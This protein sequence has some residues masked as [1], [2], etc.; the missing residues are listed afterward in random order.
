MRAATILERTR[1]GFASVPL[2][3]VPVGG[4]VAALLLAALW[5]LSPAI[6]IV[7]G[8][9]LLIG[10]AW[11]LGVLLRQVRKLTDRDPLTGAASRLCFANVLQREVQECHRSGRPV[12]V[13]VL[14][15]DNF[16]QLNE[17]FGHAVGDAVLIEVA[18]VLVK[19]MGPAATVGRLWGDA[20]GILLPGSSLSAA[21]SLLA[22]AE[23]RL[24]AR[25][26]EHDW[27]GTFSIGASSHSGSKATAEELLSEADSLM[28][29]VK[30]RGRNGIAC[31]GLHDASSAV[32]QEQ[33]PELARQP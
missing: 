7:L 29:A 18:D 32:T 8:L 12:S 21:R 5:W 15:C 22:E 14:D 23:Q 4:A 17:R 3:A 6:A 33:G 27:P 28:F 26:S 2:P 19:T 31:R 25:M 24:G 10:C 20:F 11:Q 13:A 1:V 9:I 16:K 30:R